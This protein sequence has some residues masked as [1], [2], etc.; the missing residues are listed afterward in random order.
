MN[1]T[2]VSEV[3]GLDK[4]SY[5]A[6]AAYVDLDN[7][8]DLDY[9]VNN[10]NDKAFLYNNTQNA[11]HSIGA[12]YIDLVFKG[13]GKNKN[14]LGTWVE[15]YYDNG[16]RQVAE[17][18]PCRGYL[19][20]VAAV[21]HF[22]L[23]NTSQIDS[24][25]IKWPDGANWEKI[26]EVK[27]N[28]VLHVDEK[29][30]GSSLILKPNINGLQD[31]IF[32][33]I[34][35]SRGITYIHQED[36]FIDFDQE[37]LL[38]HKLS[39]YG[40]GLAAGD[41]DG[42]GLDDILIGGT[43]EYG[44]VFFLQQA[45][46]KF[47]SKRLP[48]IV[49]RNVL[50]PENMGL[51]LFDA[52]GDR[53]LDLY[54]ANGSNEFYHGTKFYQDNFYVNDG[55]GN[56]LLDTL[57]LPFNLSSKSGIKAVDFDHDG[58]LDLFIGGRVSPG[59]Y[60]QPVNSFIYRNDS[61]KG[62][63]KF[64]D[65]TFQV[66]PQLNK[67]GLI[68][69]AIW[70]DFDNDGWED[71]I[72]AGEWM[73]ITFFKNKQG[74]LE[75]VSDK[76]GIASN[77]GWWNSISPGDFDNDGDIDY[78]IGNLGT[79]SFYKA[80]EKYPANIY[81]K[82]FDNNDQLDAITTLFLKGSDGKAR[83]FTAQNRDDVVDQLPYLKKKF[84][85]Y[86][87]F[88][89]ADIHQLFSDEQLKGALHLTANTFKSSYLENKGGGKFILTAL[90]DEAQLAPLYGMVTE[91]FNNDGNLDVAISGNDFGTEVTNGRYDALNGLLLFGDGMGHFKAGSLL[92]T[93]FYIPGDG[94]ALTKL[95]GK[96]G[97]LLLA[98]S[99]NRGPLKLFKMNSL[100]RQIAVNPNDKV[101][102]KTLSDGKIRRE[103]IYHGS[104]FLSQSVNSISIDTS[105][106]KIEIENSIGV[107][108]V[109]YV[110]GK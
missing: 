56:F 83:E 90:P 7:D 54:C 1:F 53:D 38:P 95:R 100:G 64:T 45:N 79:N 48:S 62:H 82:D 109:I 106:T 35:F 75:N 65:V 99:Q 92:Q 58:D 19:S 94:K 29:N 22:G 97:E 11:N 20:C 40:P 81:A 88:A 72:I 41:I 80:S 24:I 84:L 15:I 89:E 85:T 104:S 73:P 5:S 31:A 26:Y 87:A 36:D 101:I 28:Q 96:E 78:V 46:S 86:K 4:L 77:Q 69:D 110:K 8:G 68:C 76:S 27:A 25:I 51:L 42:N 74:R 49:G 12:N 44:A 71:L 6:G 32:S 17:N 67:I 103:E 30:A 50:L 59:K 23:G 66:A 55:K 102:F 13:S 9:V 10:I 18:A 107:K 39:Q 93:G 21:V 105:I 60:P 108:R 70:S 2:N 16:K 63:V 91:D 57:A 3:W 14:G 33:D 52:D 47:L 34:T 43:R 61:K 37:R 98:A